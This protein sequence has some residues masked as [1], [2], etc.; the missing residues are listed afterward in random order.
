MM[1][2]L[3]HLLHTLQR[4]LH[5]HTRLNNLP[6][7]PIQNRQQSPLDLFQH[8]RVRIDALKCRLRSFIVCSDGGDSRGRDR[9]TSGRG[10][11]CNGSISLSPLMRCFKLMTKDSSPRVAEVFR[12]CNDFVHCRLPIII[13]CPTIHDKVCD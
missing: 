13:S 11:A 12:F 5:I 1:T 4:F 10:L 2:F 8:R 6:I 7:Q 3:N 9:G